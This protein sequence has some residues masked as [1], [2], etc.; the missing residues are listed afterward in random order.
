MQQCKR[1]IE[2]RRTDILYTNNF[3]CDRIEL[4]SI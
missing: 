2:I 1:Y 4:V 3:Q